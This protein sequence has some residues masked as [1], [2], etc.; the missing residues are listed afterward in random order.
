LDF[1][2]KNKIVEFQINFI[3]ESIFGHE[4]LIYKEVSDINNYKIET[5][6][7]KT[8]KQVFTSI[9]KWKEK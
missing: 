9:M 1:F 6:N 7:K 4:I 5:I 8:E 3:H 2:K